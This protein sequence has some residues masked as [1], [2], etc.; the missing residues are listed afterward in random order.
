MATSTANDGFLELEQSTQHLKDFKL[1]IE[2]KYLVSAKLKL[3]HRI[4]KYIVF[5]AGS[6]AFDIMVVFLIFIRR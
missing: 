2:F 6:I 5:T 3:V 1:A 4:N